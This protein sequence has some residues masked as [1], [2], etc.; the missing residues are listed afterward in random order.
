[1]AASKKGAKKLNA[2]LGFWDE[3]G[4]SERPTVRR[5]WAPRGQTPVISSTGSWKSRSLIGIISCTS[6]G[7]KPKLFLR[8][9]AR[10]IRSREVTHAVKE[11]R[12]HLRGIIF[13]LW[14]GLKTHT[15]KETRAFLKTQRHWLRIYRFPA[16]APELNPTE[17]LWS[18]GKNKDLVHLHVDTVNDL[19]THIR[20]YKRRISSRPDLLTGFLKRSTLFKKELS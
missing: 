8:I 11:L 18:V 14:D 19:D 10:T 15:S 7:R 9:H 20:R 17:Y 4:I 2:I 12:R 13:L 5:T 16:Y 1:M 6:R 3:S